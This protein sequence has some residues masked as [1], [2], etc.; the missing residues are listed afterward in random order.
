M[1]RLPNRVV[2]VVFTVAALAAIALMTS[3]P[4]GASGAQRMPV[5]CYAQFLSG[6]PSRE[7]LDVRIAT[8]LWPAYWTP[9]CQ[10]A[11]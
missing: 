2:V 3:S 8:P 9:S 6:A 4:V 7:T 11:L 10:A 5:T 1:K